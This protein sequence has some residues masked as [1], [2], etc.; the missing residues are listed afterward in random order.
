MKD[1]KVRQWGKVI[2]IVPYTDNL[3]HWDDHNT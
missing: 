1:H 2:G 3:D